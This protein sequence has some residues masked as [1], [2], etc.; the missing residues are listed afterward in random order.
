MYISAFIHPNVTNFGCRQ[1]TWGRSLSCFAFSHAVVFSVC[2]GRQHHAID[3]PLRERPLTGRRPRKRT[4]ASAEPSNRLGLVTVYS[5]LCRRWTVDKIL[6]VAA[7]HREEQ[8][9]RWEH[10]GAV[11]SVNPLFHKYG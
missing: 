2:T 4:S 11:A 5:L 6:L 7:T 1:K 8:A 9:I 3:A 10:S